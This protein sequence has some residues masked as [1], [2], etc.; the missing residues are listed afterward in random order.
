MSVTINT[1]SM[2]LVGSARLIGVLMLIT[3]FVAYFLTPR[4]HYSPIS[5]NTTLEE[6][7]PHRFGDW[8]AAPDASGMVLA[9]PEVVEKLNAIYDETIGR[10]YVNSKGERVNLSLAYGRNQGRSLQIHKPEVCY[11]AQGFRLLSKET[12]V[13]ELQGTTVPAMR[14]IAQLDARIEPV[15]YWI[16]SGDYLVSGWFGQNK[17]RLLSGLKGKINDG[18]LVRV[19]TI[20]GNTEAGFKL[21]EEFLRELM[22]SLEARDR[23]TF[24]GRSSVQEN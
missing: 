8:T 12:A 10:I 23:V 4:E 11:P 3:A 22:Y 2:N 5:E 14:L 15:T 17:A 7:L 13:I 18:I 9:N 6:I 21:Q 1:T 20:G 16:R 19:S 24:L